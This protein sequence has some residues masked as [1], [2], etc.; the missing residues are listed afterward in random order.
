[1]VLSVGIWC[2][3]GT[4]NLGIG[5]NAL[6]PEWHWQTIE[7]LICRVNRVSLSRKD[8]SKTLILMGL[9]LKLLLCT[10]IFKPHMIKNDL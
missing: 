6:D 7:C 2:G 4:E 5:W 3:I 1:M 8:L 10:L 9:P